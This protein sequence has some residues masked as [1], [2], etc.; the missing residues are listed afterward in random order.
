MNKRKLLIDNSQK[1]DYESKIELLH[2]ITNTFNL[3]FME[4]TN[5]IFFSLN[6]ID[7]S[8]ISDILLKVDDLIGSVCKKN[9]YHSSGQ[10]IDS[11]EIGNNDNN[12]H[13]DVHDDVKS[14]CMNKKPFDFDK[15]ISKEIECHMNKT[16]KK[17]IHVK[18]SI[19]K[20]KYNK[21]IQI[22]DTKKIENNDLNELTE[23]KYI[24]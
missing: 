23:D 17:S 13:D 19:A 4:N 8:N 22:T 16:N 15:T 5:G 24:Y 18:Y 2:Y 9:M 6:E 14:E 7:D 20:K 10:N 3:N 12:V 21:Q 11:I 1:L